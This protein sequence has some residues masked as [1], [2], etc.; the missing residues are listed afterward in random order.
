VAEGE[1]DGD[2]VVLEL[3]PRGAEYVFSDLTSGP[4]LFA[5]C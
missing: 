5:T 1:A 2:T 4:V 3:E